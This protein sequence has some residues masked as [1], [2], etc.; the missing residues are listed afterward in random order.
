MFR[1]IYRDQH[2][3]YKC[4]YFTCNALYI[5]ECPNIPVSNFIDYVEDSNILLLL[6]RYVKTTLLVEIVWQICT[7]FIC[8]MTDEKLW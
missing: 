7:C 3:V 6:S 8:W 1:P 2:K 5:Q 4:K